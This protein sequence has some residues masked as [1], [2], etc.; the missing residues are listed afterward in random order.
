MPNRPLTKRERQ[1]IL[2]CRL[3]C[4]NTTFRTYRSPVS[5]GFDVVDV[6]RAT[7]AAPII[8][9]QSLT[10]SSNN[11][12][13]VLSTYLHST[14]LFNAWISFQPASYGK[15]LI[16]TN[17]YTKQLCWKNPTNIFIMSFH[18]QMQCFNASVH[19][20]RIKWW[21]HSTNSLKCAKFLVF[22]IFSMFVTA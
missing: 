17:F 6:T 21:T 1:P 3:V 18:S 20:I 11:L 10:K 13:Q 19:Q 4:K 5:Y 16:W 2:P 22:I 8:E 15:A 14:N 12:G 7:G 9:R